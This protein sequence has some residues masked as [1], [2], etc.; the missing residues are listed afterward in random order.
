MTWA[1]I[2]SSAAAIAAFRLGQR[3]EGLPAKPPEDIGLGKTH[4]GFHFCLIPGLS[5]PCRKDADAVMG[6]HHPVAAIDFRVVERSPVHAGLQIVR[7]DEAG[8]PAKEPEHPDMGL[9][10]V[11]KCLRPGRLGVGVIRGAKHR[12]EDLRV[13]HNPGF[14]INDHDLLAGVIDKDLVAGR[15]VLPHR[16]RQPPLEFPE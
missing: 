3:E 13:A 1:L 6:R 2:R 12:D 7:D 11:R 5:W 10:P 16:R 4:S 8:H 15:M 9:D 14:A